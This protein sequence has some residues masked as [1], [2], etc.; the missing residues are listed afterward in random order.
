MN[1]TLLPLQGDD[2]IR[3][4][5]DGDLTLRGSPSGSDPLETLLGP[6]YFGQKV[7]LNLEK[8][9]GID[10]S[11]ISWLMHL[12]DRFRQSQGRFVVYAMPPRVAQT[13]DLLRLTPM[14][15]TASTE[16]EALAE[17]GEG[18]RDPAAPPLPLPR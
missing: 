18:R 3:I 2:V 1:L 11:G 10:T 17:T 6:R 8:A 9:L 14:L 5:C 15:T 7:L 4:R 12:Q 13:L 16:A